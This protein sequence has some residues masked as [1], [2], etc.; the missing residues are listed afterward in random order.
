MQPHAILLFYEGEHRNLLLCCNNLP[1]DYLGPFNTKDAY[2][3]MVK[4]PSS[5]P[6]HWKR[7]K[8]NMCRVYVMSNVRKLDTSQIH[9]Q[10]RLQLIQGNG[11]LSHF[12]NSEP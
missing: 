2:L 8:V 7:Y 11:L 3:Q 10:I 4:L 12:E 6:I 1:K 9:L 5:A